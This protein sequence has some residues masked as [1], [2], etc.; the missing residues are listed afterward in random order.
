MY[1]FSSVQFAL[2]FVAS[3]NVRDW[4][5]QPASFMQKIQM[6]HILDSYTY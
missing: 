4:S 5:A 1:I 3:A 2:K 6:Q